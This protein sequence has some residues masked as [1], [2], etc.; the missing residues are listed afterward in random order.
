MSYAGLLIKWR[1]YDSEK[2]QIVDFIHRDTALEYLQSEL[3]KEFPPEE[4][5]EI[6]ETV[7]R[8]NTNGRFSITS[9]DVS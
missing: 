2:K 1:V 9:I 3:D 6:F 4:A 5:K 8:F 7:R